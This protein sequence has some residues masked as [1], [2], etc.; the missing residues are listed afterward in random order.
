MQ[1][2]RFTATEDCFEKGDFMSAMSGCP[3]QFDPHRAKFKAETET[4]PISNCTGNTDR[5]AGCS[6]LDLHQFAGLQVDPGI[7]FHPRAA[8][9]GN[10]SGHNF[11]RG[12]RERNEDR[13]VHM[14][15]GISAAAGRVHFQLVNYYLLEQ[16]EVQQ[17]SRNG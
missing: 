3:F 16:A 13:R 17:V 2:G 10:Q 8:Y 1:S 11:A 5:P 12:A 9:L 7:E 4:R 14:I 6:E 15:S